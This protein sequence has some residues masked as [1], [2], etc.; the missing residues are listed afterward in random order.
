M[1]DA[2]MP[3]M[4]NLKTTGCVNFRQTALRISKS[5]KALVWPTCLQ[6]QIIDAQ[7]PLHVRMVSFLYF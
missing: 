4:S 3:I 5:V 2:K 7:R 6:Q 1:R